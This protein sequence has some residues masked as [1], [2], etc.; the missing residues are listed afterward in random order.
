V[1]KIAYDAIQNSA[2]LPGGQENHHRLNLLETLLNT[3]RGS[4]TAL[5][6]DLAVISSKT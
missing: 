3:I 2:K 5:G 6:A 4:V 1:S